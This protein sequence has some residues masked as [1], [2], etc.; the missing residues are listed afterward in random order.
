MKGF[1][2]VF[3][4]SESYSTGDHVFKCNVAPVFRSRLPYSPD[5]PER[6]LYNMS[7]LCL[8]LVSTFVS[9]LTLYSTAS[10]ACCELC[11]ASLVGT[12]SRKSTEWTIE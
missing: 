11:I 6:F 10:V 3:Q 7:S 12:P 5:H 8:S 2:A 4:S 1:K 9:G